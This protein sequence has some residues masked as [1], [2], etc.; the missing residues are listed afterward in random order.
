MTRDKDLKRRLLE[1]YDHTGGRLLV[2][3]VGLLLV[4]VVAVGAS[5]FAT[6]YAI[7]NPPNPP[8]LGIIGPASLTGVLFA[9]SSVLGSVARILEARNRN[10]AMLG[11]HRDGDE[12]HAGPQP[13]LKAA[14]ANLK[15]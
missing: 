5:A 3:G 13:T 14:T 11:D 10:P 7:R 6:V 15:N 12:A 4:L 8:I 9:L 2:L 1:T